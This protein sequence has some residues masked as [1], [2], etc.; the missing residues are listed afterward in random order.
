M[1]KKEA[2]EFLKQKLNEVNHLKSL[3]D[4]NSEES[5]WRNEIEDVL[6]EVFGRDSDEHERFFKAFSNVHVFGK[7]Q[8]EYIKELELRETA[9]KSIIK[10]CETLGIKGEGDKGGELKQ[11]AKQKELSAFYNKIV[12]YEHLVN[13]YKNTPQNA[14]ENEI[15]SLSVELQRWYPKLE[16]KITQYGEYK[17]TEFAGQKINVFEIAF[18][19]I[20]KANINGKLNAINKIKKI[21]NKAI[22]RLEAKGETGGIATEQRLKRKTTKKRTPKKPLLKK[23]YGEAKDIGTTIIAK[24]MDEK[25]K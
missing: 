16:K 6:K 8:E 11:T 9:I 14:I 10:K 2:I 15:D 22:G 5:L 23:I 21:L 18:D 1:D 25:T 4:G 7:E 12:K 20:D 19:P 3:P 17:P 13:E 24:Y